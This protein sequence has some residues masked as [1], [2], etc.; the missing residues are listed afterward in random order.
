MNSTDGSGRPQDGPLK[1]KKKWRASLLRNLQRMKEGLDEGTLTA[2]Q[3]R[4]SAYRNQVPPY[5][6]H[7]NELHAIVPAPSIKL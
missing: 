2:Q 3:K 4:H 5:T 1:K 7:Q 6:H